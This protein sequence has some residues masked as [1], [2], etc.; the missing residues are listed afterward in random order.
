M[1][2]PEFTATFIKASI[3]NTAIATYFKKT[4]N[5]SKQLNTL[6]PDVRAHLSP[7]CVPPDTFVVTLYTLLG[8]RVLLDI[9]VITSFHFDPV[10]SARHL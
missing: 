6:P 9:L 7:P 5:K 3:E 8:S 1:T 2:P 4:E 10:L